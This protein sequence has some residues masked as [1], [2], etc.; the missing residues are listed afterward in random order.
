MQPATGSSGVEEAGLV[1]GGSLGRRFG[2]KPTAS[3]DAFEST[4]DLLKRRSF[5]ASLESAHR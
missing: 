2:F 5:R 4:H 1:A 3:E